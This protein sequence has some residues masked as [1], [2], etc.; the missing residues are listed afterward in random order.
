MYGLALQ[1]CWQHKHQAKFQLASALI[2]YGLSA[3]LTEGS[4]FFSRPNENWFLI[5]IPL[6]LVAALSIHQRLQY[7]P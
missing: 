5:W 6:S 3:G 1:R 2:V 7:K 4:N